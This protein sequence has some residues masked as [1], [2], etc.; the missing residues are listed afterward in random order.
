[1]YVAYMCYMTVK[2]GQVI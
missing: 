1:M 2:H